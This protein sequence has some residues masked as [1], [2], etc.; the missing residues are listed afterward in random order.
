LKKQGFSPIPDIGM[1]VSKQEG[2][3]EVFVKFKEIDVNPWLKETE[4]FV[5]AIIKLIEL[6]AKNP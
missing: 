2:D 3:Y 1:H 6:D 4:V 5:N